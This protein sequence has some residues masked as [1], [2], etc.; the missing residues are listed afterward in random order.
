MTAAADVEGVVPAPAFEL[1]ITAV[2][3]DHV[4]IVGAVDAFNIHQ[5]RGI[6]SGTLRRRAS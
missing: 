2:A 6:E 3:G 1:V 5:C 4:V